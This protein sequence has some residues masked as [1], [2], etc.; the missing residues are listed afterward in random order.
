MC[1]LEKV[2]GCLPG[3]QQ[4]KYSLLLLRAEG[5]AARYVSYANLELQLTGDVIYRSKAHIK[6]TVKPEAKSTYRTR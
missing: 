3:K 6:D 4:A 2:G 1:R 5:G